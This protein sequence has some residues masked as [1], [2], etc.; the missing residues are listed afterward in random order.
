VVLS[1]APQDLFLDPSHTFRLWLDRYPLAA[2]PEG[3]TSAC[4]TA[5]DDAEACNGSTGARWCRRRRGFIWEQRTSKVLTF[6][7]AEDEPGRRDHRASS[8][9]STM[10]RPSATRRTAPAC[11]RWRSI[12]RRISRVGEALVRQLAEYFR[13]AAGPSWTCR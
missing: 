4:S 7:V 11:G 8:P 6:L 9:A 2:S 5:A 1:L 13:R 12:R 10:S 3:F